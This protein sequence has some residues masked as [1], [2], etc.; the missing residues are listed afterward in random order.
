[1]ARGCQGSAENRAKLPVSR[2]QCN[3]I[4]GFELAPAPGEDNKDTPWQTR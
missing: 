3:K 2:M 4:P 1:M